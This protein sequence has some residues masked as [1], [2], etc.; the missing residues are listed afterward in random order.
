[1]AE[2]AYNNAKYASMGN[3]S[4]KLNCG[5]YLYISYKGDVNPY[6]R[7]KAADKLIKKLE[8]LM[9]VYRENLQY[10]QEL[11]KQAHDKRTKPRSYVPS[12]RVWLNSKY[13]KTK[14][15]RKLKLKFFGP[16][17]VLHLVGSQAYKIELPKQ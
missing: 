8:T 13:I 16:F 2:F 17:Q 5:Y 10:D 6:S 3:T 9:A 1:M 14:Y 11:Q 12:E 7:S 15:N 4:F